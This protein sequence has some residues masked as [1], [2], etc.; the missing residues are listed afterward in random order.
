MLTHTAVFARLKNMLK[1]IKTLTVNTVKKLLKNRIWKRHAFESAVTVTACISVIVFMTGVLV[2]SNDVIIT[3]DGVSRKYFTSKEDT[4]EILAEFG[5]NAGEFDR[6]IRYKNENGSNS[7]EIVKGFGV[8]ISVDGNT[9]T[10]GAIPGETYTQILAANNI[11][12]GEFDAVITGEKK[13]NVVRGFG[14]DVTADGK[15][16]TVGALKESLSEATVG[17]ILQRADVAV[18]VGDVINMSPNTN[19]EQGD[20]IIVGRVTYRERT[21]VEQIPFETS[22]E[23]CNLVAIGDSETTEGEN[24]EVTFVFHEKLVDGEVVTSEVLSREQTKPPITKVIKRGTALKTPYSKRDFPEI[25][26]ENG[27]PVDYQKVITGQST[28]YTAPPNAGTASGRKLEIGTVAVNP[29]IIPYG[30]LLYIVSSN[31]N[32]VYGAAI[33]AD[34]G[35]F[36]HYTDRFVAVDLFMGTTSDHYSDALRWGAKEVD[37]Y[38]INSGVY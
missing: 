13:I 12:V 22:I 7:I 34:T 6:I 18:G 21:Y 38:V 31:G 24:G 1:T 11:E 32:H 29:N 33:A 19:V 4:T 27:I 2:F 3:Q 20:E 37:V 5:Y 14:I 36:I 16:I 26:L 30:S 25:K 35:G 10:A 17:D 9:L 8:E 23:Y 15:T 28:A